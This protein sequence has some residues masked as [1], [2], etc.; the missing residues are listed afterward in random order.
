MQQCDEGEVDGAGDPWGTTDKSRSD[1]LG[2]SMGMA[3]APQVQMQQMAMPMPVAQ[4]AVPVQPFMASAVPV[5]VGQPTNFDPMIGQPIATPRCGGSLGSKFDPMT[6]QP[7]PKSDPQT[8]QQ[9]WGP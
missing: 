3:R 2:L 7:L 8:G 9:N 5:P 4:T 1:G 6:G